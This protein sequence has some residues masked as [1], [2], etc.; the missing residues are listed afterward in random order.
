MRH[1]PQAPTR[2][3]SVISDT[4]RARFQHP[5]RRARPRLRV[6]A[7]ARFRRSVCKS[8]ALS[9]YQNPW[10]THIYLDFKQ[11]SYYMSK[12]VGDNMLFGVFLPTPGSAF[13]QHTL[14]R[15]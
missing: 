11:S 9:E 4:H 13:K 15:L 1:P 6:S 5:N 14:I 8:P 10:V 12:T 3:A 7:F 2:A